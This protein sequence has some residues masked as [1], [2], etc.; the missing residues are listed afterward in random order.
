VTDSCGWIGEERGPPIRAVARSSETR[1]L[2]ATGSNYVA[3]IDAYR[4]GIPDGWISLHVV[5]DD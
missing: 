5:V 1:T 3:A 2:E 4:Q